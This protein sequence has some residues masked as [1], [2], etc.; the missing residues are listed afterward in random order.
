MITTKAGGGHVGRVYFY[1][2]GFPH[3]TSHAVELSRDGI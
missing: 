1:V 3:A 2:G